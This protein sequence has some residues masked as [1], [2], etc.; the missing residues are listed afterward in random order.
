MI[1]SKIVNKLIFFITVAFAFQVISQSKHVIGARTNCGFFSEFLTVLGHI[2]YCE[3]NAKIPVVYW[4]SQSLYY[5]KKGLNGLFNAWEYYFEPLS[6]TN[7][8]DSS[9]IIYRNYWCPDGSTIWPNYRDPLPLN[10]ARFAHEVIKKYIKIKPHVIS[11][12][13]DFYEKNM[14][15]FAII[16][17]HWRGTN[18]SWEVKPVAPMKL[19]TKAQ[20]IGKTLNRPYKYLIASDEMSFI[21]LAQKTLKEAPVIFYADAERSSSH[22]F[23][24]Y[25]YP[26]TT[27]SPSKRGLDVLVETLMLARS[28]IFI[29]TVSNVSTG[30]LFFNPELIDVVMYAGK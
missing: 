29:H 20:E 23:A 13:N 14:K 11:I 8:I 30:A 10:L 25:M 19:L 5:E 15:N 26:A 3:K 16:G 24:F 21:T 9:D 1:S 7:Y 18:K 27:K 6:S 2:V 12:V 17:V 28:D 22:N 4:D